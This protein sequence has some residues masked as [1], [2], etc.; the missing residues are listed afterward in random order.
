MNKYGLKP[1]MDRNK[2]KKLLKYIYNELHPYENNPQHQYAADSASLSPSVASNSRS[3]EL[4]ESEKS[5]EK[6]AD[7]SDEFR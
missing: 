5:P 4:L 3:G 2:A 1:G 7:S 6:E